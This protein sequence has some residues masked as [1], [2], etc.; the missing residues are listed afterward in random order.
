VFQ[1]LSQ[2]RLSKLSCDDLINLL[3]QVSEFKVAIESLGPILKENAITGRVLMYCDLSELK[4]V[5]KLIEIQASSL[6]LIN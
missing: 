5:S 2:I 6:S 1:D 4:T 3:G